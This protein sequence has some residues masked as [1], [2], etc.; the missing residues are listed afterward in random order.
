MT[1]NC[2]WRGSFADDADTAA[3]IMIMVCSCSQDIKGASGEV[4]TRLC[5]KNAVFSNFPY[6]F[7][8]DLTGS[9]KGVNNS[10]IAS[11]YPP[12][13]RTLAIRRIGRTWIEVVSNGNQLA[14]L[15]E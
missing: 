13:N 11:S 2:N 10:M 5:L 14:F 9:L 1:R 6:F 15:L 7:R 8:N 3:G 4:I 12:Q